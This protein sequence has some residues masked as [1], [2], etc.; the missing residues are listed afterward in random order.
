MSSTEPVALTVV[1]PCVLKI[2]HNQPE[3][4]SSMLDLPL[5][6]SNGSE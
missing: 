2:R 5:R 1:C 4:T 3:L 6:Q